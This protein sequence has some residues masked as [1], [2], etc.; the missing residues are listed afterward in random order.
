MLGIDS[1]GAPRGLRIGGEWIPAVDGA[2]TEVVDPATGER[3]GTVAN[4]DVQDGLAAV[5]AAAAAQAR[6]AATAPRERG[7]ILR[8]AFEVLT[9]ERDE[10]AAL[11]VRENGKPLTEARGELGQAA[12]F[13]R[14]FSEEAVRIEGSLGVAP[15]GGK[16]VLVTHRPVG[17]ALCI[18]PWNFPAAMITRKLAPALAAGC[19]AILKPAPETPFT[20]FAIVDV[21]ERAGLPPGVVNVVPS[22]R[23]ADM[24]REI[25]AHPAVRKVSFTG[26]TE[27][28][29]TLLAASAPHV[30]NPSME[31]GG[32]APFIVFEDADLDAAVDGA[33]VAKMRNNG[34]SCTA[35]NRFYVAEPVADAF[36]ERLT[37]AVAAM[38]L[39]SGFEDDVQLGPLITTGA[40]EKVERLTQDAVDGGARVRTGGNAAARAGYFFEPTVLSG[41]ATDAG[42]LAN[43]IFGPVAPVVAFDDFDAILE[44]VNAVE[45]GLVAYVY[46][47][48]LAR[49]LRVAESLETGMV[50]LN[51]ALVAEPAAPFGGVKQSGLGRE[52]GHHGILEFLEPLYIAT[53]W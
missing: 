38:R 43:E 25:L 4:A 14:W 21:L 1:S 27:T 10:L 2:E 17:V 47:G 26:S 51:E 49:G 39:G 22:D 41:L 5:E 20:A 35:A 8:R 12:E 11:V 50:G 46:T 6:W 16:R 3:I 42:I 29:R 28:G 33:V 53:N 7:E 24:V 9:A 19:T 52:G 18:T 30:I 36:T 15:G 34:Q 40:R 37:A 45:H 32:N 48:D 23:P 13:L 31:L 44:D